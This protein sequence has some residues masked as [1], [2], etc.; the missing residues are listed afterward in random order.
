MQIR[1]VNEGDEVVMPLFLVGK[2][3]GMSVLKSL[4]PGILVTMDA[5]E[6]QGGLVFLSEA[7][8]NE[9][10]YFRNVEQCENTPISIFRDE[11]TDVFDKVEKD[12]ER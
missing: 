1:T 4:I 5:R 6:S 11:K 2:G 9:A 12:E 7:Q 8:L 10:G 3:G